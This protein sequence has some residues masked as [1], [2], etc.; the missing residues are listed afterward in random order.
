MDTMGPSAPVD[1]D[2]GSALIRLL[3]TSYFV[4]F[5]SFMAEADGGGL[6]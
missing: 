5:L 6:F 3:K 4:L 1:T 2:S